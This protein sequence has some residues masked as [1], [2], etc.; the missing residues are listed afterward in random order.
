[1]A[2]DA[3]G[4]NL[5][6]LASHECM[7]EGVLDKNLYEHRWSHGFL[8]VDAVVDVDFVSEVVIG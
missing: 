3:D 1:M 2:V 8:R 7:D 5:V 6:T 4:K